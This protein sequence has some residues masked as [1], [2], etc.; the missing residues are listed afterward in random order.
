MRSLREIEK[1]QESCNSKI[2]ECLNHLDWI[3]R[4]EKWEKSDRSNNRR[5]Y[6][7]DLKELKSEMQDLCDEWFETRR[8]EHYC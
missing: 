7:R 1:A 4:M 8:V 3:A 5:V 2:G 6:E